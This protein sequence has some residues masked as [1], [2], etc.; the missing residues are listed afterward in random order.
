MGV[1][2]GVVGVVIV[3]S[4]VRSFVRLIIVIPIII[5]QFHSLAHSLTRSFANSFIRSLYVQPRKLVMDLHASRCLC[6]FYLLT[7]EYITATA[8]GVTRA[9]N[10]DG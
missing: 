1:E 7:R 9:R 4:F 3:R 5:N 6:A 2:F 8:A 10:L